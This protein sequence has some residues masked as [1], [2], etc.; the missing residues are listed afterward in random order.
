MNKSFEKFVNIYA[1][2]ITEAWDRYLYRDVIMAVGLATNYGKDPWIKGESGRKVLEK[3][4]ELAFHKKGSKLISVT[5]VSDNDDIYA[6]KI[7]YE[8]SSLFDGGYVYNYWKFRASKGDQYAINTFN[9]IRSIDPRGDQQKPR[10]V[11]A[12]EIGLVSYAIWKAMNSKAMK[13]ER[14]ENEVAEKNLTEIYQVGSKIE[15]KKFLINRIYFDTYQYSRWSSGST[16]PVL[17]GQDP[18][19]GV[20]VK[21]KIG[22]SGSEGELAEAVQSAV[23]R[24][25]L[26]KIIPIE[27]I[28]SKATVSKFDTKWKSVVFNRVS[29]SKPTIDEIKDLR[30]KIR[31]LEREL[32]EPVKEKNNDSND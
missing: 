18:E 3:I 25:V 11:L 29:I 24:N 20:K 5:R 19:T 14:N 17:E 15:N 10:E 1:S 30:K 9:L 27:V 16:T 32:K 22:K 31:A 28:V 21:L 12:T 8:G 23:S 13:I 7:H 26:D 4:K 2:I 6:S